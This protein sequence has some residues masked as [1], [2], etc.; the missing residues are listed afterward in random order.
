MD[1]E[2]SYIKTVRKVKNLQASQLLN[3][4]DILLAANKNIVVMLLQNIIDILG[5][6]CKH[7]K[8]GMIMRASGNTKLI[9][10]IINNNS[11]KKKRLYMSQLYEK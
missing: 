6:F 5:G 11:S 9:N 10:E 8:P 3:P 2:N 7:V 1:N 4:F